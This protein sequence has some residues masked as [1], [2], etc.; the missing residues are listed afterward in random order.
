MQ[1]DTTRGLTT[2]RLRQPRQ[3]MTPVGFLLAIV[4]FL[5]TAVLF[6]QAQVIPND[7]A[8]ESYVDSE[9]R[10]TAELL[11]QELKKTRKNVRGYRK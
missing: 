5:A 4:F 1:Y 9:T 2:S 7:M 3:K 10:Q 8:V 6:F 11:Q